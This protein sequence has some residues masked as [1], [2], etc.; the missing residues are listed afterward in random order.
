MAEGGSQSF[1][2]A[3]ILLDTLQQHLQGQAI[4]V[5][6]MAVEIHMM[7]HRGLQP[8]GLWVYF[9][10]QP[11]PATGN[12]AVCEQWFNQVLADESRQTQESTTQAWIEVHVADETAPVLTD[13][14]NPLIS[15]AAISCWE[16]LEFKQKID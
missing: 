14:G 12:A 15:D 11:D 1:D 2:G 4:S 8:S 10:I 16:A 7:D 6:L 13:E 5:Q 3:P 9:Y